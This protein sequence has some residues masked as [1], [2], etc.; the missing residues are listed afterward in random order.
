MVNANQK[1]TID[2]HTHTYTN[3]EIENKESKPN[4]KVNH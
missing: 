2:T 4:N 1:S 3:T